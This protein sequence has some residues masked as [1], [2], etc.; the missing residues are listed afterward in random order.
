M[1]IWLILA[2]I[3]L[4]LSP[5]AMAQQEETHRRPEMP[6][7][8]LPGQE[9][10]ER[11]AVLAWLSH[12][13]QVPTREQLEKASPQARQLLFEIAQDESAFLMHRHRALYALGAWADQEVYDYLQGLLAD[14]DTEDG[15]RH[16]LLPIMAQ[17][18]GQEALQDLVP[19]LTHDDPQIR[20][21][22]AGAIAHIP[23][24]APKEALLKAMDAEKH[25]M[26]QTQLERYTT[27]IR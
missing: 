9:A 11:E 23:G 5:S 7:T 25:P 20:I 2:I 13:H 10:G 21:S 4:L 12:Y 3:T 18:F 27:E 8:E 22:A 1:K 15:L 26:V 24:E 6:S 16:H 17:S 19:F 14:E